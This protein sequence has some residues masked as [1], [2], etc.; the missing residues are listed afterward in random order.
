MNKKKTKDLSEL[1]KELSEIYDVE[2]KNTYVTI[3]LNKEAS[4]KFFEGRENAC[5]S[6]LSGEEQKNFT[7][8]MK[9]IKD[10][11]QKNKGFKGVLFASYKYNFFKYI[12]LSVKLD[13]S[14]VVDSS[15]YIRPLA[16]IEDEWE[17]FTLVLLN[18]NYAK[19]FS[20]SLGMV[21]QKKN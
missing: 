16:R 5:S 15:P 1:I 20:V 10:F 21:E 14:L 7:N 2:S 17:S 13:N 4:I 6:L 3:S 9:T 11:L 18:T 12:S 8:T 19:I